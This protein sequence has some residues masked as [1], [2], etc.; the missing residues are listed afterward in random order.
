MSNLSVILGLMLLFLCRAS[1]EL[2][3]A[4]HIISRLFWE[5]ELRTSKKET[6]ALEL[7]YLSKEFANCMVVLS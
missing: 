5:G 2:T 3:S 1:A 4:E 6:E 7:S